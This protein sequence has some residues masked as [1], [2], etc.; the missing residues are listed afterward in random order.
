MSFWLWEIF[1]TKA[2]LSEFWLLFWFWRETPCT[3]SL[4]SLTHVP[5]L[6]Y[7]PPFSPLPTSLFLSYPPPF[8]LI[9]TPQLS[10][11]HFSLLLSLQPLLLVVVEGRGGGVIKKSREA[12]FNSRKSRVPRNWVVLTIKQIPFLAKLPSLFINV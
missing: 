5:F 9:P 7:P 11:S 6:P 10:H 1:T 8:S 12:W 4:F 2:Y 3:T